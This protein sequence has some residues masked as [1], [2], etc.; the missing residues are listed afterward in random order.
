MAPHRRDS[1][2]ANAFRLVCKEHAIHLQ[3]QPHRYAT[4]VGLKAPWFML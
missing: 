3:R 4:Q 1:S 2:E